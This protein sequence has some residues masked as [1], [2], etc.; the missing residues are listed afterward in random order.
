MART[1]REVSFLGYMYFVVSRAACS[2][3]VALSQVVFIG[4]SVQMTQAPGTAY[5]E[6]RLTQLHRHHCTDCGQWGRTINFAA[7][8]YRSHHNTQLPK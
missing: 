1:Q 2:V 5:L 3:L 4:P 8:P 7:K 6:L